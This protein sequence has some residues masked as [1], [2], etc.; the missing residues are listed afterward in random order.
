MDSFT[1]TAPI[2]RR[3]ADGIFHLRHSGITTLARSVK[4]IADN[5]FEVLLGWAGPASRCSTKRTWSYAA[6][7]GLPLSTPPSRATGSWSTAW[8]CT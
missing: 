1:W 5:K 6:C 8:S 2:A 3:M 4:D 7:Y